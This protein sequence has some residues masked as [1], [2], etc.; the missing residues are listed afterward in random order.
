MSLIKENTPTLG[1]HAV[2]ILRQEDCQKGGKIKFDAIQIPLLTT[3]KNGHGL[4]KIESFMFYWL[5]MGN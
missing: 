2:K 4:R 1:K 3:Q 5:L